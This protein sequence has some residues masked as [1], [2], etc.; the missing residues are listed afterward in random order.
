MPIGKPIVVF[1]K[2]LARRLNNP[3]ITIVAKVEIEKTVTK[4]IILFLKSRARAKN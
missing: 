3:K 2:E 1:E 4:C